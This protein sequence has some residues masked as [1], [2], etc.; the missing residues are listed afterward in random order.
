M[1][2]AVRRVANDV[3]ARDHSTEGNADRH[4][5]VRNGAGW[6][7][8]TAGLVDTERDDRVGVLVADQQESTG[9]VNVEAAGDGA[10]GRRPPLV[11]ELAR[12][13]VDLEGDD[14]IVA[15]I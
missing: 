4:R 2:L 3:L 12:L 7:Q 15:P 6:M 5:G 11:L 9:R 13:L 1:L 8:A 10:L 14:T